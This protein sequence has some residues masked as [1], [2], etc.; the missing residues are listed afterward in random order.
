MS[1]FQKEPSLVL[2]TQQDVVNVLCNWERFKTPSYFDHALK[3]AW[4]IGLIGEIEKT[5]YPYNDAIQAEAEKRLALTLSDEQKNFLGYLVYRAQQFKTSDE[6]VA[7]GY[8]P[9]TQEMVEMAFNQK[10][11]I[12]TYQ[13]T[14][15]N[16]AGVTWNP[17]KVYT[18]K[19]ATNGKI[20]AFFPR[21]RRKYVVVMG[22]PAKIVK[23]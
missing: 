14:L 11:K 7:M 18:P 22:Q 1:Y 15:I 13:E 16:I 19:R 10:A 2:F 20:Y 12:E 17:K 3:S 21:A 23:G 6:Y 9:L 4:I 8:A 5:R